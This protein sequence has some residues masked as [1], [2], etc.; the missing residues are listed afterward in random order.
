MTCSGFTDQ[1]VSYFE[2][3]GYPAP[4]LSELSCSMAVI[5]KHTTQQ[6][7][8][9]FEFFELMP[10]TDG[11]CGVDKFVISGQNTNQPIPVLCGINTGQHRRLHQIFF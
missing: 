11:N 2:S 7:L 6:L 4:S 3:P 5:L 8:L 9:E 1:D 10:P